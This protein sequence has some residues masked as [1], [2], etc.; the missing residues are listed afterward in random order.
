MKGESKVT[1]Q[2]RPA[3]AADA[4]VRAIWVAT[5]ESPEWIAARTN[6]LIQQL[7]HLFDIEHWRTLDDEPWEGSEGELVRIVRSYVSVNDAYEP[8][9]P[10]PESGYRIWLSGEGP[11]VRIRVEINAGAI[12]PGGRIPLHHLTVRI[13]EQTPGDITSEAAD[14]V[15][16]AVASTWNPAYAK[17]T[18]SA[19]NSLARRGGWKI[20]VGYRTWISSDVGTVSHLGDQLSSTELAGGTLISAPDDW[21]AARVV[22]AMTATL[23]ENG[24]DEVPH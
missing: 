6:S 23:R 7:R 11:R 14:A 22:E 5:G 16:A 13:H 24:M 12:S 2:T 9:Q 20:G 19:T 1:L 8:P 15:C 18:D 17:L 21:P 3:W 4:F 10:E